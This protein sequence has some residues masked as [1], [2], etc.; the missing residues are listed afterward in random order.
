MCQGLALPFYGHSLQNPSLPA[1][2][3]S[4][5]F[6]SY[7]ELGELAAT[8]A[9]LLADPRQG[10]VARVGVL[11]SRSLPAFAGILAACWA[12]VTFVPLNPKYPEERLATIIR[13][14]QLSAIVVDDG[15]CKA[16][17]EKVMA[18][19]P[20]LFIGPC[21]DDLALGG[22]VIQGRQTLAKYSPLP[23]VQLPREKIAYILFTSGTTG[24]P[25][26]VM[27]TTANAAHFLT[28]SQE[29]YRLMAD[30]RV[31][32]QSE[33]TFDHI[34]FDLFMA[35]GAGA[36]VHVVPETMVMA[37]AEFIR[38]QEL[39]VWFAVPSV[40][41][42]LKGMKLL[43]PGIFPTLRISL[44]AGEPLPKELAD[45][46]QEAAP[47]SRVDNL[48]GPTEV[49]VDCLWQSYQA[50]YEITPNR[51]VVA[52]GRPYAGMHAAIV[53]SGNKFLGPGEIGELA[54]SG[55]QVSA[56][57]W[58][59]PELTALR[60]PRLQH[61]ELGETIWYLTGDLSYQDA[62]GIFHYLGRVDNQVKVLGQR[63]ELEDVEFHLRAVCQSDSVAVVAWPV[64]HGTA[65][66][67][68]AFVTDSALDQKLVK[69]GLRHRL[70]SYMIP[71]RIVCLAQLPLNLNGK[72]DRKALVALLEAEK[73]Q[74]G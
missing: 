20:P 28:I 23:P 9:A 31:S 37:P 51:G 18:C 56:G 47:N 52:I 30:D 43:K 5:K 72:V 64:L 3:V 74:H 49:T 55:P 63:V 33:I 6:Y 1:L 36:S 24:E 19:C 60:F 59:N 15:G 8:M 41:S 32:Q 17:T 4:G 58:N 54:V 10:Q 48:Y 34:A 29:R 70:L 57:Y 11:A 38:K 45:A 39:T 13:N 12:G 44:F 14:S 68:I 61:P 62:T 26:G 42:F 71:R 67:L 21:M 66:G 35:W 25:K 46:W 7:G 27:V 65:Q 73:T 22:V 69:E 16:L 2:F 50:P 40:I 53:D